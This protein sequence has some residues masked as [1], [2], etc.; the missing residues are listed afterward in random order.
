MSEET[1]MVAPEG[2]TAKLV[3][4]KLNYPTLVERKVD[5]VVEKQIHNIGDVVEVSE[6]KAKE[7]CSQKFQG[8]YDFDGERSN[9]TATRTTIV[10]ATR[11][12]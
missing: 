11:V 6:E 1:K 5:G 3:K 9:A 4:V 2:K 8:G 7:M 12:A 10:R